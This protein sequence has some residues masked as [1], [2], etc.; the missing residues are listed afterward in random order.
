MS[1][2][3]PAP[4]ANTAVEPFQIDVPEAELEDLHARLDRT[5]WP[6]E[7]PDTGWDYGVPQAYLR[8][9]VGYWRTGYDWRPRRRD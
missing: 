3:S 4:D 8:E 7:L 9:L 1:T 2:T 5:R 6:D